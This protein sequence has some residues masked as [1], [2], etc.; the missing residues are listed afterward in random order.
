[1]QSYCLD[2]KVTTFVNC[3]I[4]QRSVIR[5]GNSKTTSAKGQA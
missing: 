2:K 3:F 5:F 4:D 1:M